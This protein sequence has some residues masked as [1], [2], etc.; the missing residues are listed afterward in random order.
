MEDLAH[1]NLNG[2]TTIFGSNMNCMLCTTA[3]DL[4]RRGYDVCANLADFGRTP[5][6]IEKYYKNCKVNEVD[7]AK[8]LNP[9]YNAIKKDGPNTRGNI[10]LKFGDSYHSMIYETDSLGE[11]HI[12]DAQSNSMDIYALDTIN[13]K[14]M[15]RD[16][17][18]K[19]RRLSC[20]PITALV[21][22]SDTFYYARTDNCEPNWDVIKDAVY[23]RGTQRKLNRTWESDSDYRKAMYEVYKD[24]YDNEYY[25]PDKLEEIY[26]KA[27][28]EQWRSGRNGN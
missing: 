14:W 23:S 13:G 22:R 2:D 18:R 21:N 26:K 9:I 17:Y 25:T 19:A 10:M 1:V 3:Y 24:R 12:H 5:R 15:T 4:R 8:G 27:F 11:L 16:E 6:T 28:K 7:G 20:M